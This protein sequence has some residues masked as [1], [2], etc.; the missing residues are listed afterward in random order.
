MIYKQFIN[1]P[2]LS[3]FINMLKM[4]LSMNS[5]ITKFVNEYINLRTAIGFGLDTLGA[6]IGINRNIS[7]LIFDD[8]EKIG[9][10]GQNLG[11]FY[12]SN[13]ASLSKTGNYRMDDDQYR[14]VLELA[15][16]SIA[17]PCTILGVTNFY[18]AFYPLTI[19]T[20]G[21][22]SV[23]V[24][25]NDQVTNIETIILLR[26]DLIPIPLGVELSYVF[27]NTRN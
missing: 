12:Q 13:Y 22:M 19:V 21:L 2:N 14:F 18:K 3:K 17:T 8:K 9:F 6:K 16:F 26:R 27:L 1:S 10:T 4:S 7:S 5:D 23:S 11:N 24:T 25:I 15:H 20:E